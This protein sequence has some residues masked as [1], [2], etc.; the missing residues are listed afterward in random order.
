MGKKTR[1]RKERYLELRK[2]KSRNRLI[3]ISVVVV[4]IIAV[5]IYLALSGDSGPTP[6]PLPTPVPTPPGGELPPSSYLPEVPRICVEEV[7]SK[8]D[9][10]INL[11]I[12]DSRSKKSYDLSHIVGAISIPLETMAEPYSDLDGYDEIVTYCT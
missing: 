11:A 9:G 2:K 12:I 6:T 7:K 5:S 3:I 1:E 10:G 4:A 8:L